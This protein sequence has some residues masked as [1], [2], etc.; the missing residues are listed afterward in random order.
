MLDVIHVDEKWF[1]ADKDKRSYLVFDGEQP[2]PRFSRARGSFPRQCSS[3]RSPGLDK[4]IM[5]V[6][7]YID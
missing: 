4:N 1:N 2:P 3:L 7:P 5:T 6:K